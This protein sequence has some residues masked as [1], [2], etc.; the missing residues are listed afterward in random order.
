MQTNGPWRAWSIELID[1]LQGRYIH[2]DSQCLS[3]HSLSKGIHFS[4][5]LLQHMH[6]ACLSQQHNALKSFAAKDTLFNS[7]RHFC[8]PSSP[9]LMSYIVHRHARGMQVHT[10]T[11]TLISLSAKIYS[12]TLF[13]YL[14]LC[15][16]S[17]LVH[18]PKRKK[19]KIINRNY[20]IQQGLFH[21]S[22]PEI[23]PCLSNQYLGFIYN[24]IRIL[25]EVIH[26][27]S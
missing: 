25:Q 17:G 7:L 13:F 19:K 9:C 20:G 3:S 8:F 23:R 10:N 4:V 15:L 6:K 16:V 2:G 5:K 22:E 18:I 21:V 27:V 24:F 14:Q 1:S 12:R 11:Q 26:V